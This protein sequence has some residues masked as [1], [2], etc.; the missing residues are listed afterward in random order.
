MLCP[1][2]MLRHDIGFV[3]QI[4]MFSLLEFHVVLLHTTKTTKIVQMQHPCKKET[5]IFLKCQIPSDK[6]HPPP[7]PPPAKKATKKPL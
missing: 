3:F 1:Y 2:S 7:S 4:V 6:K 5:Q